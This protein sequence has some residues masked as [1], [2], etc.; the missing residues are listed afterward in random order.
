MVVS[1]WPVPGEE[2]KNLMV[3]LHTLLRAGTP[4][5]KALQRAKQQLRSELM[6]TRNQA[7]PGLVGRLRLYR[8]SRIAE[9]FRFAFGQRPGSARLA[10]AGRALPIVPAVRF[11]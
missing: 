7:P 5:A 9:R 6:K 3:K 11:G 4:T 1:L 8:R 2:T 10:A